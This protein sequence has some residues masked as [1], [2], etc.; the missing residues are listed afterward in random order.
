[1]TTQ[2]PLHNAIRDETIRDE[3]MQTQYETRQ[4]EKKARVTP[5][6]NRGRFKAGCRVFCWLFPPHL[7]PVA[8]PPTSSSSSR[9]TLAHPFPSALSLL[10]NEVRDQ[11]LV[12][13]AVSCHLFVA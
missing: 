7:L 3:T 11:A 8:P 9:I 5:N 6:D 12:L 13:V 10:H 2:K 1:M 4:S